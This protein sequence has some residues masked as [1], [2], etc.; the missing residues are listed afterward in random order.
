MKMNTIFKHLH[1]R[2]SGFTLVEIMVGIAVVSILSG[3]GIPSYVTITNRARES[4]TESDMRTAATAL[5]MFKID[6]DSYPSTDEG[7]GLLKD[8]GYIK[9][10]PEE[11][12]WGNQYRYSSDGSS[13]TYRSFGV[14]GEAETEDD[15]VFQN[16]TMVADGGYGNSL[17]GTANEPTVIEG[18]IASWNMDKAEDNTIGEG[19][20]KGIING[21]EWIIGGGRK[22]G[23]NGLK[24]SDKSKNNLEIGPSENI[25]L[26]GDMSF[27]M[28]FNLDSM[29]KGSKADTLF[30]CTASGEKEK[31]NTL[32]EL[33]INS[34]GDLFYKHEY[35]KGKDQKITFKNTGIKNDSWNLITFTRDSASKTVRI[36][37]NGSEI[38]KSSYKEDPTGGSST[39]LYIAS[40]RASKKRAINGTIDEFDLYKTVLTDKEIKKYYENNK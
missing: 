21:A 5:E 22:K 10:I 3:V 30:T 34:K 8:D 16:G 28:W 37:L 15:I 2:Q 33:E 17:G 23:N 35:S 12:F 20:L 6:N 40:D 19:D 25:Q 39:K 38:G 32:Y 26:T 1:K 24:F 36:Y 9:N 29:P 27:S 11:D 13:Y 14:D 7:I 31:T 4:G 18:L